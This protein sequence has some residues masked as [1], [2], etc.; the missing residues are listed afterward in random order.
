MRPIEGLN[1]I[2][3]SDK[4]H[5]KDAKINVKNMVGSDGLRRMIT[6]EESGSPIRR[7]NFK[8]KTEKYG[9]VF[10][11]QE[12][13]KYS[14]KMKSICDN[15]MN[16]TGV[17]L[18]YSQYID[19]GVIPI[20]LALEELGFTRAQGTHSLFETPPTE[21][22]DAISMETKKDDGDFNPAKYI[23]ITG[24]KTVSPDN[25]NELKMA[26]NDS[27]VDGKQVKVILISQ[28]G[29]EGLDFRFI[30]QVH[31]LEPWWNMNRIE[32]IIGRAVRTCSHKALPFTERNVEIYLH[33]SILEDEQ[34]E[35]VDIYVYRLAELK[36]LKIGEVSRLLK[37]ISV[38]CLL[39]SEQQNFTED[40]FDKIVPQ[41]LSSKKEIEYK[42]G[43]KPFSA[44]C[45]YMEKC[46]YV[47]KPDTTLFEADTK[48]DTYSEEYINVNNDKIIR[49]IKMLMKENFFYRKDDLIS[50]INVIN[51]YPISQINSALHQLVDGKNEYI[52]DKYDRLGYLINIGD[53]Y[54]FQPLE[55]NDEKISVFERSTPLDYKKETLRFNLEKANKDDDIISKINSENIQTIEITNNLFKEIKANYDLANNTESV[56]RGETNWYILASVII[57]ELKNNNINNTDEILLSHILESI[58]FDSTLKILEYFQ[59]NDELSDFEKQV[60]KYYDDEMLENDKIKCI[61]LNNKGKQELVK[62]VENSWKTGEPEDYTKIESELNNKIK[63]RFKNLNS[64]IG[65]M[66]VFK[67][68]EMVFKI[69]NTEKKRDTGARCDQAQ[70]S[71]SLKILDKITDFEYNKKLNQKQL[72]IYQEFMLRIHNKNNKDNKVWFLSPIENIFYNIT[73]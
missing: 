43:D 16:S 50:Q 38:D 37:T 23:M 1:I 67:N 19:G 52:T 6:Y 31:I 3:P 69:K 8:Y 36:A 15:I 44:I 48:L 63:N 10:S 41:K 28:A 45:D 51:E 49:R 42:I 53:L 54:L 65:L 26:T 66:S 70:K 39:N 25:V 24:D 68:N 62:L 35:A 57:K 72:C 71:Q 5:D 55:I 20:A 40:N 14:G 32:Q 58:D 46:D 11:P 9:R 64:L 60:K 7:K 18:V 2:Y 4:L 47:C 34:K 22:I 30:R 13:G 56:K 33:G 59:L 73:N 29:S 27:N 12:L 61:I 17:V 21:R